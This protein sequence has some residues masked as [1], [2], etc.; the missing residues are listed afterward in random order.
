MSEKY[1]GKSVVY[2]L[3]LAD[4]YFYIGRTK[5]LNNRL[6][7]H[8]KGNSVFFVG[9]HPMVKL[10]KVF[11]YENEDCDIFDEEAIFYRYAKMYGIDKCRGGRY[12]EIELNAEDTKTIRDILNNSE[13]NACYLCHQSGHYFK[14]CPLVKCNNC[15]K[16][17]HI[18]RYCK[19][20]TN[21]CRK[22]GGIHWACDCVFLS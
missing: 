19:D 4:G 11:A 18:S 8:K 13:D 5:S 6:Q 10:E 2:V 9:R 15:Q 22:C 16:Y 1:E 12:T 7:K 21:I 14:T 20:S 17:G 3:E